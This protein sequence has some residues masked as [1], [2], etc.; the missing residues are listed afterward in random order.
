M[1]VL[2]SLLAGCS[3]FGEED[4]AITATGQVVL[5]ET[6]EPISGLSIALKHGG[7]LAT[8]PILVQTVQTEPGG[9]FSLRY[10]G[11]SRWGYDVYIN[12]S[13]YDARYTGRIFVV[14]PGE[15]RDFGVV[16]IELV[17]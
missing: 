7:G 5:A 4:R 12:D 13:P 15:T 9:R 16:E 17:D 1:L 10:E 6:G 14:L 2:L 3:L 11:G 8:P